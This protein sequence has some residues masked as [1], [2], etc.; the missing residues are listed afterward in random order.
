MFDRKRAPQKDRNGNFKGG[1]DLSDADVRNHA[2]RLLVYAATMTHPSARAKLETEVWDSMKTQLDKKLVGGTYKLEKSINNQNMAFEKVQELMEASMLA[3]REANR[4]QELAWEQMTELGAGLDNTDAS[5]EEHTAHIAEYRGCHAS[6]Q[7]FHD[8]AQEDWQ[9]NDKQR[10]GWN[11]AYV[12]MNNQMKN[13]KEAHD[14]A[15]KNAGDDN[16]KLMDKLRQQKAMNKQQAHDNYDTKA[17]VLA[18]LAPTWA[19]SSSSSAPSSAKDEEIK[20]LKR[21]LLVQKNIH[22]AKRKNA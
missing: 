11:G 15:M 3:Q 7:L 2:M 17:K 21:K 4:K 16:K 6:S 18:R 19:A 10:L 12:S 13:N 9:Q 14:E 20:K 8:A 22:L 1:G 5:F